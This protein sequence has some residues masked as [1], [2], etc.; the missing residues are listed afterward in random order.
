MVTASSVFTRIFLKGNGDFYKWYVTL[1]NDLL[2]IRNIYIYISL[3]C[4]VISE[5]KCQFQVQCVKDDDK[6]E[7]LR[8]SLGGTNIMTQLTHTLDRLEDTVYTL[9]QET[10]QLDNYTLNALC[11]FV[12]V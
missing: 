1:C 10:T 7:D 2:S 9:L 11:R 3:I 5:Q 8:L 6:E 4:F 12:S